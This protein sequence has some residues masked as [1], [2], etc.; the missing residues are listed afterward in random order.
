MS[1]W[2]ADRLNARKRPP[3]K[4]NWGCRKYQFPIKKG[5]SKM[6][7]TSTRPRLVVSTDGR[8][9]VNHAGVR[10]LADLADVVGL[11]GGLSEAMEATTSRVPVHDRGRLLVDVAVMLA[12]GG[13]CVSDLAAL[14]AQPELFG[15]VASVPTAWRVIGGI[16]AD[17]LAEIEGARAAARRV[18]WEAGAD[19]GFYVLDLDATLVGS[20]SEKE[21]ASPT[22]KKGFGFHPLLCY[23]DGTGEALSGM[24]RPGNAGS[25]TAADHIAV[26][27]QALSQL[28]VFDS[29]RPQ[30]G[31]EIVARGDSAACSHD[32]VDACRERGIRFSVGFPLT[33]E[34]AK[35]VVGVPE[36]DWSPAVSADGTEEQEGAEV[37]EITG[38]LDLAAWPTGTRALA[39]RE[40]PHPGAQ[41]TFTDLDGHRFQVFL[42]DQT[43]PDIAFL[44]ARQRGRARAEIL[45]AGAKDSGLRNLPFSDFSANQ[46]WLQLVLLCQDLVAW[47]Q[48]LLLQGDLGRAEPKRL[49]FTLWHQAGVLARSGRRTHLRLQATWPWAQ[50]LAR[51]FGRLQAL[52]L[53]T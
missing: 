14:R 12:D 9:I 31:V 48:T 16:D 4:G 10:L 18:A 52:P 43:D 51:A 28:P 38:L 7:P 47:T 44:E 8:G 33:A 21:G 23:L 26:L 13:T 5:T 1:G 29:D 41:L 15:E 32:F 30:E 42:T 53:T 50:Q 25:G 35:A 19:P 49:R 17:T 37:A 27:D 20:H 40:D 22:Y 6:K 46:V 45:I 39:R 24:L 3:G 11:T 34:T 36:G 2:V